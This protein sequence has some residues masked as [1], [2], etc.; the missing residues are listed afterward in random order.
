[1]LEIITIIVDVFLKLFP[2]ADMPKELGEIISPCPN[3]LFIGIGDIFL[4]KVNI[5]NSIIITTRNRSR[6]VT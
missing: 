3:P 4:Y 2:K 6:M 5:Y 1:M